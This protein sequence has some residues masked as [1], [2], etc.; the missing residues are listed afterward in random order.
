M[1]GLSEYKVIDGDFQVI[2]MK[3][4]INLSW[5]LLIASTDYTMKGNVDSYEFY[6]N[7]EID[8]S[9]RD[10]IL[11]TEIGFAVNEEHF[12]VRNIKLKLSLRALDFRATGLFNDEEVSDVLSAVIS[13]TGPELFE[14][15]RIMDTLRRLATKTIDAFLSTN[16]IGELLEFLGLVD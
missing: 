10:F 9:A 13:D 15:A 4:N 3:L 7:G 14:D 16:S 11:E 5:P 12:K 2:G 1:D 6:G 8:L